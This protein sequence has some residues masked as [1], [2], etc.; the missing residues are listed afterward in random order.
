[1]EIKIISIKR[2]KA[3]TMKVSIIY[4]LVLGMFTFNFAQEAQKSSASEDS[5]KRPVVK[6]VGQVQGKID[7]EIKSTTPDAVE[8]PDAPNVI[9][10]EKAP[11][12]VEPKKVTNTLSGE[13]KVRQPMGP[14]DTSAPRQKLEKKQEQTSV[15]KSE[16]MTLL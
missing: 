6:D 13:D 3:I 11:Q 4:I 15:K 10:F 8:K 14:A 16:G 5:Q 7:K 2:R 1:M 9:D 12:K